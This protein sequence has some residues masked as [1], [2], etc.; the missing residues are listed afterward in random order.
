MFGFDVSG[1]GVFSRSVDCSDRGL[2]CPRMAA[3]KFST[4]SDK[5]AAMW[6]LSSSVLIPGVR[7]IGS[8]GSDAV[9]DRCS[10][11][12]VSG[13]ILHSEGEAQ[14][15][16]VNGLLCTVGSPPTKLR[17]SSSS[18]DLGVGVR[19]GGLNEKVRQDVVGSGVL[20]SEE[21]QVD[22]S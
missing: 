4:G 19:V 18:S 11:S 14:S 7:S 5:T 1:S 15:N 16:Y 10:G 12:V 8:S 22:S 20:A 17:E 9:S 21:R 13:F 3:N 2:L 6:K